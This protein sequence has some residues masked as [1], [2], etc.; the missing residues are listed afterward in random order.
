MRELV[1][2]LSCLSCMKVNGI[3]TF[4]HLYE[5]SPSLSQFILR[6]LLKVC[7]NFREAM[8]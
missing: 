1:L 5:I 8:P 4:D 2:C 7:L 6:A 3:L